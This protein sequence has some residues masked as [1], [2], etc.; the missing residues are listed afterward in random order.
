VLSYSGSGSAVGQGVAQ[1]FI[2]AGVA[3]AVINTAA[4]TA[5]RSRGV[6]ST[7]KPTVGIKKAPKG[8]STIEIVSRRF[9][10]VSRLA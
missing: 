4:T 7:G 2:S 8:N 6:S 1:S 10:I 3:I 5:G 9:E